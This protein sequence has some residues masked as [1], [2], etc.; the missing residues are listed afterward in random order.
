M[1]SAAIA[2]ACFGIYKDRDN[3]IKEK[4]RSTVIIIKI[5]VLWIL[6]IL[7]CLLYVFYG[8]LH[9]HC[10]GKMY[11]LLLNNRGFKKLRKVSAKNYILYVYR[12]INKIIRK[13]PGLCRTCLN[14]IQSPLLLPLHKSPMQQW[15]IVSR[16]H[17][18]TK[19]SKIQ[20]C[21]TKHV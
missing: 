3:W 21:H 14:Q 5:I 11:L 17:L 19:D 18:P 4:R 10:G 1:A 6:G 7:Q 8:I 2:Y 20:Y 16:C 12:I 15:K 9:M 13:G